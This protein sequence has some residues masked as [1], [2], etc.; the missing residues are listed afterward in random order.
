MN[1]I[2]LNTMANPFKIA[3]ARLVKEIENHNQVI[4]NLIFS[5][6]K[7]ISLSIVCSIANLP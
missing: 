5:K 7:D 4:L 1:S 2:D 3:V 6:L